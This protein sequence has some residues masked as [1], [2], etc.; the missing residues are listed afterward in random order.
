MFTYDYWGC[1]KFSLPYSFFKI[2]NMIVVIN[3]YSW[4]KNSS[5]ANSDSIVAHNLASVSNTNSITKHNRS[6]L[7]DIDNYIITDD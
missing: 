7:A 6:T 2:K 1:C 3:H 5:L 4:C